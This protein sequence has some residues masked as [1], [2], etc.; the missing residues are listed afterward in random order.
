MSLKSLSNL[1][2]LPLTIGAL[3]QSPTAL[4]D[5]GF[6]LSGIHHA[7]AAV[8][9]AMS[10]DARIAFLEQRA[11]L[12]VAMGSDSLRVGDVAPQ[13]WTAAG[14]GA[15]TSSGRW[16]WADKVVSIFAQRGLK[17]VVV[18]PDIVDSG[19]T[20]YQNFIEAL[21]ER[22]D[23]DTD[24]G[25]AMVDN[26]RDFPDIDDTGAIT[27]ADWGAPAGQLQQW[28]DAHVIDAIE[29]GNRPYD[30]EQAGQAE[31]GDYGT[32]LKSAAAAIRSSG[33]AVKVMLAGTVTDEQSASA[34]AARLGAVDPGL[35]DRANAHLLES[36]KDPSG[37]DVAQALDDF[38]Q[39][40]DAADHAQ[41]ERWVGAFAAA[42]DPAGP[43]G[44][45]PC[46]DRMQSATLSKAALFALA[47]GYTHFGYANPVEAVGTDADA[48]MPV[49]TGLLTF[50][51]NAGSD[52]LTAPIKTRLSY[53]TWMRLQEVLAGVT[54]ADVQKVAQL[55]PN[56][57][58]YA[59]GDQG[60][61]LWYD[62]TKETTPGS[63]YDGSLRGATLKGLPA[64]ALSV[65]ASSMVPVSV[66]GTVGADF[67][68]AI[69]WETRVYPVSNGEA[70][71]EVGSDVV[72]VKSSSDP[73]GVDAGPV[74]DVEPGPEATMDLGPTAPPDESGCAISAAPWADRGW[75]WAIPI[76]FLALLRVSA[77]RDPRAHR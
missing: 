45:W 10:D 51:A 56:I 31:V 48:S 5:M 70:T 65:V 43:C 3:A 52:P 6:V 61:M 37:E 66:G 60:W 42:A 14:L 62:W 67:T 40:L 46:D 33:S 75:W 39:W 54:A 29:V 2:V 35:F 72:W 71:V 13:I 41:A 28:A 76:A 19:L 23:G 59:L 22:Y 77:C 34:F 8:W 11:D 32:Q 17:L 44:S 55:G 38:S 58:G 16:M 36:T 47:E 24:F 4:A 9:D 18:V 74:E 30:A 64:D 63:G 73:V 15:D 12:A 50:E 21:A 69:E 53:A 20:A 1:F 7:P 57:T 49:A 26:N 27:S 25:V 68:A